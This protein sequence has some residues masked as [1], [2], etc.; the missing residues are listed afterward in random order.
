MRAE[1]LRDCETPQM[2]LFDVVLFVHIAALLGGFAT[3]M[4]I[5]NAEW[6]ARRAT[7]VGELRIW[8]GVIRRFGPLFPVFI[9]L[10]FVMGAWLLHLSDG[11]FAWGDGW[12]VTAIAALVVLA[13]VGGG[14]LDPAAKKLLAEVDAAPEGPVSP[15]LRA[16]V[17]NP[18]PWTLGHMNTGLALGTAF[19]MT[20]KPALA[21][22]LACLAVGAVGGALIGKVG[23]RGG[24]P[25]AA[26]A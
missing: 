21:G 22:A 10:L 9:L 17:L 5:H 16:R 15:E 4:I 12:V 13:V 1:E 6:S 26:A 25:V 24:K 8:V 7:T 14:V 18:V 3:G 11:E 19:S 23:S 2:T 20:T